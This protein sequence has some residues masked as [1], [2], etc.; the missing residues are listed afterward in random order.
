M[1][2]HAFARFSAQAINSLFNEA[3]MA[4]K[5]AEIMRSAITPIELLNST[6]KKQVER[7][8]MT[9]FKEF[10]VNDDGQTRDGQHPTSYVFGSQLCSVVP[11]HR[12]SRQ[13][14]IPKVPSRYLAAT[15]TSTDRAA[16]GTS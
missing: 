7:Q 13:D 16:V 15:H 8:L 4:A 3:S 10:D 9:K 11:H 1:N 2:P 6:V 12:C 14:R 5:K